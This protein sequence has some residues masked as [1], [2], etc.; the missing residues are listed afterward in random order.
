MSPRIE[1][2][3][4]GAGKKTNRDRPAPKRRTAG[5][6]PAAAAL[7]ATL[8][9]AHGEAHQEP[10]WDIG[11]GIG[12]LGYED[13]RGADSAHLFPIPVITIAYNGP[14]FKADKDGLHGSLLE[15]SWFDITL[16]FDATLPVSNDATRSGMDHLDPTVEAGVSADFHL[17]KS[18]DHAIKL[19]FKIPV[20]SAF[21]LQAPPEDIGW[22]LTPGFDLQVSTP[23][24]NGWK[25]G[26]YT[27]PLFA[28]RKYNDYFYSVPARNATPGRPAYEAAGGY[29]GTQ[30]VLDLN[31]HF[32]R[33][34]IAGFIR[35]DTLDGAVFEDSPLVQRKYYWSAGVI[36]SWSVARSSRWVEVPD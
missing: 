10:L 31:K 22:T 9:P 24:M 12:A 26:V 28:N 4:G 13:Y 15:Q 23:P 30:L 29:A 7:L 17:W 14:I 36:I 5:V 3:E 19:D 20:R 32:P 2:R 1:I 11:L 21:T 27:G 8:A 16:S 33:Y 18:A 34:W 35:Y 25:L 6:A